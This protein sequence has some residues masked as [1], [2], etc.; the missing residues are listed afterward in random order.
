M[1]L[2]SCY[3]GKSDEIF[4]VAKKYF[5]DLSGNSYIK[6]LFEDWCKKNE[7]ELPDWYLEHFKE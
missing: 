6:L 7:E 5:V 1:L 4:T 3:S 2:F